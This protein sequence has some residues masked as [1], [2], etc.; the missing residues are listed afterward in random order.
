MSDNF[1]A[2]A[3]LMYDELVYPSMREFIGK[4]PNRKQQ[5]ETYWKSLPENQVFSDSFVVNISKDDLA[6]RKQTSRDLKQIESDKYDYQIIYDLADFTRMKRLNKGYGWILTAIEKTSRYAWAIPIK[7]KQAADVASGFESIM[8][9]LPATSWVQLISDAGS[10]FKGAF[11]TM[12][13]RYQ[14]TKGIVVERKIDRTTLG[15]NRVKFAGQVERF[16]RT[17]LLKLRK[18]FIAN[19]SNNWIE[20]IDLI[21]KSYNK[22]KKLPEKQKV[23]T[24]DVSEKPIP[25]QINDYVRVRQQK[26]LFEKKSLAIKYSREVYQITD[27]DGIIVTVKDDQGRKK[28]KF[29][30]T[31]LVKVPKPS[32]E[33]KI[34]DD[35]KKNKVTNKI[36]RLQSKDGIKARDEV[37]E[38][39]DDGAVKFKPR[40]TTKATTREKPKVNYSDT[41]R[42]K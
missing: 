2:L 38:I 9:M 14:A 16:N 23:L 22:D 12:L 33:V 19:N 6:K 5:A 26:D 28:H 41:K 36:K 15:G 37:E 25:L 17:I 32:S 13:E 8:G 42:R 20:S 29:E 30:F 27:I 7:T 3:K 1:N 10:E 40:L 35:V 39:G 11:K 21:L 4:F 31:D 24:Y 34:T 18:V